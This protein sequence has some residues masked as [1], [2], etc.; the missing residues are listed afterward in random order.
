MPD[1]VNREP[2]EIM[3]C[4]VDRIDKWHRDEQ[5]SARLKCTADFPYGAFG[6]IE[7]LQYLKQEDGIER[8]VYHRQTARITKYI[9]SQFV[10]A[11]D[12]R[13]IETDDAVRRVQVGDVAAVATTDVKNT[14][15]A[16]HAQGLSRTNM[17]PVG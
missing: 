15:I 4:I 5:L 7:V 8:V 10:A 16:Q 9:R 12:R 1:T 13:I 14:T 3:R 6:R 11:V 17:K 2:L